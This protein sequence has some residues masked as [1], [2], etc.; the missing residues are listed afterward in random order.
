MA[1]LLLSEI[2]GRFV[3]TLTDD[4]MIAVND[5][6]EAHGRY[7]NG[8]G[9]ADVAVGLM[10]ADAPELETQMELDPEAGMFVAY[11]TDREALARLGGML[12][13]VFHDRDALGVAVV[14]APYEW[15]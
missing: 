1:P 11:G 10:R 13:I 5:V 7:G 6:F 4:H 3:L 2:E 14:A 9:W 12:A 15:D 8:Y